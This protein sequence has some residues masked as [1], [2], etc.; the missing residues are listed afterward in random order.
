MLP[1]VIG[2][3]PTCRPARDRGLV[4]DYR[5]AR[6]GKFPMRDPME[7]PILLVQ[8][9]ITFAGSACTPGAPRTGRA[10]PA[11]RRG[12]HRWVRPMA[13]SGSLPDMDVPAASRIGRPIARVT[14]EV[15]APVP[16]VAAL[17]VVVSWTSAASPR[18]A[19][20]WTVLT[21]LF[22]SVLP[23]LRVDVYQ[24]RRKRPPQLH[25][26]PR[27]SSAGGL[28]AWREVSVPD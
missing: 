4:L 13:R 7:R 20:A 14:T 9:Q 11:S 25:R 12:S 2:S 24:G 19:V 15:F 8:L 27:Y 28:T 16:T 6:W 10:L 18:E 1:P 3:G 26:G 5:L 22:A 21:V 17:L 23:F